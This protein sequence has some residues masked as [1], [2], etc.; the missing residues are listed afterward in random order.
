[1]SCN[2][3]TI[4][5]SH[6]RIKISV[7]I[8]SPF[9]TLYSPSFRQTKETS[10]FL[11]FSTWHLIWLFYRP[12]SPCSTDNIQFTTNS[13]IKHYFKTKTRHVCQ[14]QTEYDS[15]ENQSLSL[16]DN[17]KKKM[18]SSIHKLKQWEEEGRKENFTETRSTNQPHH[19]GTS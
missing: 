10:F 4:Q 1:M 6:F 14:R 7:L 18:E 13:C 12:S 8:L 2:V 11:P 16:L 15:E 9:T 3:N 5:S 19:K 17:W